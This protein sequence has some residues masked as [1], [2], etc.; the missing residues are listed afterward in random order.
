MK[1]EVSQYLAIAK[2]SITKECNKTLETNLNSDH[3]SFQKSI[4][5]NGLKNINK[6]LNDIE[7]NKLISSAASEIQDQFFFNQLLKIIGRPRDTWNNKIYETSKERSKKYKQ[8][9]RSINKLSGL[10]ANLTTQEYLDITNSVHNP[11]KDDGYTSM[12]EVIMY[13]RSLGQSQQLNEQF[14]ERNEPKD[15]V[16]YT[17][18]QFLLKDRNKLYGLGI[19]ESIYPEALEVTKTSR[20]NDNISFRNF[21]IRELYL[22]F[23]KYLNSPNQNLIIEIINILSNGEFLLN[24]NNISEITNSL[25]EN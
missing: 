4:L 24:S 25:R 9:H 23:M 3:Y 13:L 10:L 1:K 16:A 7:F 8:I 22:H 19:F 15:L 2:E 21:Q 18:L 14:P 17:C 11:L 20:K 6:V 12:L 5:D